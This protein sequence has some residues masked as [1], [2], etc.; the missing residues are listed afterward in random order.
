MV[1]AVTWRKERDTG[2]AQSVTEV[3][4]VE[5][6]RYLEAMLQAIADYPPYV[7]ENPLDLL[8]AVKKIARTALEEK[9]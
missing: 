8:L 2:P 5:R 4:L 3:A 9:P 7:V 6:V 1:A